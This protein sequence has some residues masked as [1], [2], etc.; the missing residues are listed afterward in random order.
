MPRYPAGKV[1]LVPLA[2]VLQKLAIAPKGAVCNNP[3][4][5]ECDDS[6]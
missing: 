2:R 6:K 3:T 5:E 4:H 1:Q